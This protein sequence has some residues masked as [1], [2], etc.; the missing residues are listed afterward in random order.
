[1]TVLAW[2]R[3]V[4]R[5]L[6]VSGVRLRCPNCEQ[7]AMFAGL[8]RPH[9]RCAACGV[10]FERMDGESIG[11]LAITTFVVPSLALLGF[12]LTNAL[13]PLPFT[14]NA[15]VWGAA[16]VLGVTLLYRHS[17]AAWVA[18]SYLTGGV[19]ADADDVA[20]ITPPPDTTAQ[21]EQMV[22]AFRQSR[23]AARQ[24]D[25]DETGGG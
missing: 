3:R 7:G 1:M 2:L 25:P 11:G 20:A 24:P 14:L 17:R 15:L 10:R 6:W 18:V 8:L 21:R 13:T 23:A 16:I 22:A 5:K 9:V 19:Y 4:A 12:F